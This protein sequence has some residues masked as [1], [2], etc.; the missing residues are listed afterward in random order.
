MYA[1]GDLLT[2]AMLIAKNGPMFIKYCLRLHFVCNSFTINNKFGAF[3]NF[4]LF[5]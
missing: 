5:W 4:L 3:G 2:Y 1:T